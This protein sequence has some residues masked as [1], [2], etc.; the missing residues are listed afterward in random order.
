MILLVLTILLIANSLGLGLLHLVQKKFAYDWLIIAGVALVVWALALLSRLSLP[1]SITL[2]VWQPAEI[3]PETPAFILDEIS[4]PLIVALAT[5]HLAVI[6]VGSREALS[7]G[8]RRW[9]SVSAYTAIGILAVSAGNPLTLLM[10]WSG[11]DFTE[12]IISLSYL[13]REPQR[14]QALR[15]FTLRSTGVFLVIAS[16]ASAGL[17][18]ARAGFEWLG[19]GALNL[20]LLATYLRLGLYPLAPPLFEDRSLRVSLG[21]VLRLVTAAA[22]LILIIRIST[23]SPGGGISAGLQAFWLTF[24]GILACYGGLAWFFSE[25]ELD[26]RPGWILGLAS[27]SIATAVGRLPE[28]ALAW[29]LAMIFSGGL[30]FLADVRGKM[31]RWVVLL[32][33]IGLAML[34]FSPSWAGVKILSLSFLPSWVLFFLASVALISGYIM[35]GTL[36]R[37]FQPAGENWIRFFYLAGLVLILLTY[38]GLGVFLNTRELDSASLLDWMGGF[39]VLLLASAGIYWRR[40]GG[41]VPGWITSLFDAVFSFRWLSGF[42]CVV[43]SILESIVHFFSRLIEGEGSVLWAILWLVIVVTFLITGL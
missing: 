37:N 1:A 31:S 13:S 14:Q 23:A 30:L 43:Y 18:A 42:L 16:V 39:A 4:W 11:L 17:P 10:A 19:N 35:K 24:S 25:D 34:P 26:G 28:A 2:G 5:L 41:A 6:L 33:G 7:A 32:G 36:L 29:M 15:T 21:T 20:L 3:F 27:F 12:L 38:G 8:W 40:R 9:A 22:A